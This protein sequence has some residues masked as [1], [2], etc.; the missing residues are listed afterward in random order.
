MSAAPISRDNIY[1]DNN[2]TTRPAPEVVDAV[3]EM[4]REQWGNPSSVHRLGQTARY[5][6]ESARAQV[7]ALVGASE[8]EIVFTSGGTESANLAI[9]GVLAARPER[10]LVVTSRL[11]HSAVRELAEA[12]VERKLA[13]V[14][15]LEHR[16]DGTVDLDALDALLTARST[17]IAVV[18]IMWAN[19]ETGV[20]Q[21]VGDI[22]ERCRAARVPFHTDATQAVGRIPVDLA[23]LPID[24]ATFSAHKFHGPKGVGALYLRRGVRP[25]R[26]LIGGPQERELRGGTENVPGI[27]GMGVATTLAQ[28][29]LATDERKRL[30]TLR[31]RLEHGILERVPSAVVNGATAPRLWNTTNIGFPKLEAEAILLLLSERGVCA[32]AG[33]ACSSGSLDPSPVLLAMGVPPDVAHGSIRLSLSRETTEA[34]IDAAI[35]IVTD[36]VTRLSRTLPQGV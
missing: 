13:E 2:A 26:Q 28:T 14:H 32:S 10:R 17:E 35:D 29:W 24:L 21:P 22:G 4:M 5:R 15:W 12:L 36:A 19:N 20:V 16:A 11:E 33:A 25:L 30:S 7:A 1:L 8:R 9:T 27:V 18:S 23:A 34:E 31:D 6:I 3:A